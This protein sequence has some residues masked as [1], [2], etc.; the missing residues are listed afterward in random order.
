[1]LS[2]LFST[3]AFICM[4]KN[5]FSSAMVFI[6]DE[7]ILTKFETGVI[8]ASFYLVYAVLQIFAGMVI[9]KWHPERFIT[10]GLIGAG[11]SNLVIYFNQNYTVM[12]VFWCLNAVLQSA[13]WPAT[14]KL[15]STAITPSMRQNALFLI[16]FGNPLG[17]VTCYVI[18]AIVSSAWQLNFLISAVGLFL[19]AIIFE[20]VIHSLKP[21]M[22]EETR[23]IEP[24]DK[25]V[26]IETREPFLPIF[27]TS[28]LIIAMTLSFIR[29]MFDIGIKSL[30]PTMINESYADVTP[31]LATVLN[32]VILIAGA[33][34]P[35]IGRLIYPRFINNE[36]IAITVLFAAAL[37]L[38]ASALL[39]GKISYVLIIVFFSL[40]VMLMSA[41]SLLTSTYIAA[42][43]NSFGRGGTVAG[44]LNCTASFGIVVS[45]T[46]F[47][48]LAEGY[49]WHV[50]SI[51]WVLIIGGALLFSVLYIPIWTRFK[52]RVH[53]RI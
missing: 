1:M 2:L 43:Y 36:A 52:K 19:N 25:T 39:L 7:G 41:C 13:V 42:R 26:K 28:G 34:G 10:V 8:T 40:T 24:N 29:T 9:D 15:I 50:T 4:T 37:P 51:S 46:L 49:G 30:I 35:C 3:Y 33:L 44:L 23:A 31:V 17:V 32:I 48:A 20:I 5:C 27:I 14:F 45:N 38:S 21:H 53:S 11:V 16:T 12:L 22:K 6:V 18:A 47:T